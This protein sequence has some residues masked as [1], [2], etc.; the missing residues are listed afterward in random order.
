MESRQNYLIWREKDGF[1]TTYHK[2]DNNLTTWSI[3]TGKIVHR[4]PIEK[5]K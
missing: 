5:Q 2:V 1:F 3:L 4:I